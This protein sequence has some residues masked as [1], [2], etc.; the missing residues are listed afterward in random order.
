MGDKARI[1]FPS[2][3]R[4]HLLVVLLYSPL[5]ITRVARDESESGRSQELVSVISTLSSR[6]RFRSDGIAVAHSV[7]SKVVVTCQAR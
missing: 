1:L 7:G 5:T 3:T 4:L 2:M 6:D